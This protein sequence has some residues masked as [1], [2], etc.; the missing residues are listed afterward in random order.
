MYIKGVVIFL[1]L[2]MCKKLNTN[3]ISYSSHK[4]GMIEIE[5]RG[6]VMNS[7][8][9]FVFNRLSKKIN[10]ILLVPFDDAV[11]E[12]FCDSNKYFLNIYNITFRGFRHYKHRQL[13]S[14]IYE[15]EIDNSI[16][17]FIKDNKVY[18]MTASDDLYYIRMDTLEIKRYDKCGYSLFSEYPIENIVYLNYILVFYNSETPKDILAYDVRTLKFI[19]EKKTLV[20]RNKYFHNNNFSVIELYTKFKCEEEDTK[21]N[22]NGLF[23]TIAIVGSIVLT[24]LLCCCCASIYIFYRKITNKLDKSGR[25]TAN[26]ILNE[27]ET[28]NHN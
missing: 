28:F 25:Y 10:P 21:I 3:K 20:R 23:I 19:R 22:S 26:L 18:F 9:V 2:L 17:G 8:K 27:R 13:A 6:I 7:G 16:F 5:R 14:S 24:V 1:I 11:F 4:F 15:N 12:I